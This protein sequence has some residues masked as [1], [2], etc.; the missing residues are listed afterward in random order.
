MSQRCLQGL[1]RDHHGLVGL[2]AHVVCLRKFMRINGLLLLQRL[3]GSLLLRDG[4]LRLIARRLR[5][6][7]VILVQRDPAG[8]GS[9]HPAAEDEAPLE[10]DPGHVALA[11][12]VT[13]LYAAPTMLAM[14][15]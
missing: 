9:E 12:V 2:L 13:W 8:A 11:L 7:H 6:G 4:V 15:P 3:R 14:A 1:V 10:C 5:R